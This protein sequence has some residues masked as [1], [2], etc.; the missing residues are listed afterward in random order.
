MEGF[1]E[2]QTSMGQEKREMFHYYRKVKKRKRN[3]VRRETTVSIEGIHYIILLLRSG[4]G[5]ADAI[6]N[7]ANRKKKRRRQK[8][9]KRYTRKE[10]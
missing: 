1:Y 7:N 8:A 6:E 3:V 5:R 10:R 9:S 2:N 4:T